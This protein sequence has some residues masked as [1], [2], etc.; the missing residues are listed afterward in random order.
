MSELHV[1]VGHPYS[2]IG[3]GWVASSIGAQLGEDTPVIKIDPML[4]PGFPEELG[5]P[6]G[7]S[8]VTD[9]AA[10]YQSRGLEFTPERNIVM[11]GWMSRALG[12][13]ALLGGVLGKE[14]PKTTYADL[15]YRLADTL[16]ELLQ[17]K[18]GVIEMGGCPDDKEAVLPADAVR[19][20]SHERD[21]KLH[22]LTAYDYTTKAERQYDVKTRLPVRAVASTMGTYWGTPLDNLSVYVRRAN[23][24]DDV[25]DETLQAATRK[26]AFKSQLR[27]EQVR[28]IPNLQSPD[29]L[30]AYVKIPTNHGNAVLLGSSKE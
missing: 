25:T 15:S 22:L 21:V 18:D 26:V 1:V 28:Y 23:V 11:G 14:A 5:I 7:D 16:R 3:K 20:L 10:T 27:P 2:D 19:V 17:G 29:Q 30:D 13:S 12:E 6:M 9:D 4:S 8:V 24:P